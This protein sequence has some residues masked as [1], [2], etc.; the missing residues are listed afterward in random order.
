M[1]HLGA[2]MNVDFVPFE[3]QARKA[4]YE[5]VRNYIDNGC[6]EGRLDTY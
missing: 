1:Q 4:S 5:R 2:L 6:Q 3:F